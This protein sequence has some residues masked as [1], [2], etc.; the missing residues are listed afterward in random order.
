MFRSLMKIFSV[1]TILILLSCGSQKRE[2]TLPQQEVAK[3][4]IEIDSLRWGSSTVMNSSI[5]T[6][7]VYYR[8]DMDSAN[9][10]LNIYSSSQLTT[11]VIESKS[12][13]PIT[14]SNG[15]VEFLAVS[16]SDT[17]FVK[18]KTP[19]LFMT[20]PVTIKKGEPFVD[21]EVEVK[22]ESGD[23]PTKRDFEELGLTYKPLGIF[24]K[25][26]DNDS[27]LSDTLTVKD[28]ISINLQ[29]PNETPIVGMR[30][31]ITLPNGEDVEAISDSVG[32]VHVDS[33]DCGPILIKTLED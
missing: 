32:H 12:D 6:A 4:F 16:K 21:R 9:L 17:I 2:S 22:I 19:K 26:G 31:S 23:L 10:K 24:L 15:K 7:K 20:L 13:V 3:T 5:V 14:N 11:E 28:S 8:T 29:T 27:I 25:I 18:A 30:L 33:I 1:F